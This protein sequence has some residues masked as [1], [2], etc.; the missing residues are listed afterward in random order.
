MKLSLPGFLAIGDTA[1]S[2]RA[3]TETT[4][5]NPPS[6]FKRPYQFNE[7]WFSKHARNW[8]KLFKNIAGKPDLKY[9]EIGVWEGRSFFW[10]LENVLTHSSARATAV[11]RFHGHY[12]QTFKKNASLYGQDAKIEIVKGLSQAVLPG[13]P[14]DTYD[15]IYIDGDHSASSVFL[16]IAFA[17]RILKVGGVFIIDDVDWHTENPPETTPNFP[18]K[19]F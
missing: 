4:Q 11:D 12:F 19:A 17:W 16:D 3:E 7:D 18:V 15:I 10:M 8:P 6:K 9:L 5:L 13:L 2:V 1:L 14:A